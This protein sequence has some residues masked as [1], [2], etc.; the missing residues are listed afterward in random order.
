MN[1]TF[2]SFFYIKTAT[3]DSHHH[4]RQHGLPWGNHHGEHHTLTS[5]DIRVLE[6]LGES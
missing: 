2:V 4:Q 5:D 1:P 6:C 3:T